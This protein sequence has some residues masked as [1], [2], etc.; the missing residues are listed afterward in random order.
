MFY[1]FLK[2]SAGVL[3]SA[4]I[5]GWCGYIF[6]DAFG[7]ILSKTIEHNFDRKLEGFKSELKEGEKDIEQIRTYLSS[8]R[9]GRNAALQSK[10]FEAAERMI[11][12]RR[13]LSSFNVV[14]QYMQILKLDELLK[15][16]NNPNIQMFIE[17]ITK[18]L[19]LE[20][21]SKEYHE[22]DKDTSKLYLNETTIRVFEI[23]ESIILRAIAQ[24]QI[25]ALP[26]TNKK[27]LLIEG[28]LSKKIIGFIP[29]SIES[30][31]KY[32]ENYVY[33]CVDYFHAEILKQ[34]RS[35]LVGD[36]SL[37][38][39][40]EGAEK[41]ALDFQETQIKVKTTLK[42]FGLSEELIKSGS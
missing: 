8:A 37:T 34:L 29:S 40:M 12:A 5:V 7:K 22:L 10:K 33:Y 39:D 35:E 11:Q 25:L 23:Y 41:L 16:K 6:R 31:E 20:E 38:K 13:F 18:P 19:N 28:D 21:K 32:G 17:G 36:D 26:I 42:Q 4:G 2:W 1:D 27:G 15:S 24:L 3:T 9:S 30:F 14:V